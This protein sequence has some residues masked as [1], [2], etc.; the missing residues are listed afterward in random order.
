MALPRL[1]RWSEKAMRDANGCALNRGDVAVRDVA[2]RFVE[3]DAI[4]VGELPL[5]HQFAMHA[6][7]EPATQ[8]E[9]ART[10]LRNI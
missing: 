6:I 4:V 3:V 7:A 8:A 9:I 10:S 1:Q 2:K 5:Q